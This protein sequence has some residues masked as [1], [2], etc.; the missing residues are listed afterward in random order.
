VAAY[1]RH[2]ADPIAARSVASDMKR[3]ERIQALLRYLVRRPSMPDDV[4]ARAELA[5]AVLLAAA[6]GISR[7]LTAIRPALTCAWCVNIT[8]PAGAANLMIQGWKRDPSIRLRLVA[9]EVRHLFTS[10]W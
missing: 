5:A 7:T 2:T 8:E 4:I 9:A 3:Y 6:L 1:R 10:A